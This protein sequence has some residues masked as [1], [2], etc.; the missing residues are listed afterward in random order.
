MKS[1]NYAWVVNLAGWVVLAIAV[2]QFVIFQIGLLR[3]H[4]FNPVI[5]SENSLVAVLGVLTCVIARCLKNI[6]ARLTKIEMH[7]SD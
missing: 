4:S 7:T 2:V 3:G 1:K 5:A 6:E